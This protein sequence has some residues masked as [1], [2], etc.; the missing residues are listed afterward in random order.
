MKA[1]AIVSGV[2]KDRD[3]TEEALK[4][5]WQ[6]GV[7]EEQ[8]SVLIPDPGI[9]KAFDE[10]DVD[11]AKAMARGAGAGAPVGALAG[12]ALM[13]VASPI[14]GVAL[15]A[16]VPSGL[17]LGTIVGGSAGILA[18][19]PQEPHGEHFHE[20]KVG[21]D[22]LLVTVRTS[23][24]GAIKEVLDAHGACCFLDEMHRIDAEA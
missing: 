7:S 5:L 1:S 11:W 16:G 3:A 18:K 21:S 17:V 10:G 8:V 24:P 20:V 23:E 19:V 15:L 22:E 2:F 12:L 6:R 4:A 9:Y 13:A 14:G